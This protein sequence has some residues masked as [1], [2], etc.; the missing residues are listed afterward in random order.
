MIELEKKMGDLRNEKSEE[1]KDPMMKKLD[2]DSELRDILTK[3]I[4]RTV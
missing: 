1:S 3:D 2:E 4:D